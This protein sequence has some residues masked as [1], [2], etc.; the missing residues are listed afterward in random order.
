[1]TAEH[2]ATGTL[3]PLKITCTSSDCA[4]GL[5]C[6]QQTRKLVALHQQGRCRTCGVAL[7]DWRRVHQRDPADV[8]YTF[9]ALKYE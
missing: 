3:K 2:G 8:S 1:M 5:H 9:T 6:F 4:Q 7:I